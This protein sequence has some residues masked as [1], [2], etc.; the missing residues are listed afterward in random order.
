[1]KLFR[2]SAAL[3]AAALILSHAQP[4][5]AGVLRF[6]DVST[7]MTTAKYW[8]AKQNDAADVLATRSEIK[9]LNKALLADANTHMYD[10]KNLP[11]EVDG[12]VLNETLLKAAKAD[13]AYMGTNKYDAKGNQVTA[14]YY[15]DMVE[16]TQSADT[17]THPVMYGIAVNRT[18]IRVFP[19]D[20]AILDDSGDND[21]DNLYN[22]GLRVNEPF[23][24]ESVSADRKFY[25]GKC[26]CCAGW[27]PAED[28]AIC[29]TR[30]QWLDAWNL[31]S[32][33][34]L[35]VYGSKVYTESSNTAPETANRLLTLGTT[36]ELVEAD[37]NTE[38]ITNRSA[39]NNYVVYLPVR[40]ADG[41]FDKKL[42]LISQNAKVKEGFFKLTQ[43][44]IL[45]VS[46]EM[47]GDTYGWGGMLE[48][49]DCSGYVRDVYRCFG[50]N[51]ARNTT[52]QSSSP[53]KKCTFDENTTGEEKYAIIKNLPAGSTLFFPGHEMTYLGTENGKIYV[54]SSVSSMMNPYKEGQRLR[55]RSVALNTLDIKRA[56]GKTWLESLSTVAIPF[57]GEGNALFEKEFR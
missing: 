22:S 28:V 57:A 55:V 21:F 6:P 15:T 48:S 1:M 9:A 10:L 36:L 23:V 4:L 40:K 8:A 37:E 47:L 56:N 53:V 39:Y 44:N 30:R 7:K 54:I 16:N 25:Y 14:D 11:R 13:A 33:S 46:F 49:D 19:T 3:L 17:S 43:K 12:S 50:L 32:D 31:E 2:V 52:W 27:V 41:S 42:A 24:I 45:K 51:L 18:T 26:D 35:L 29:G 38:L 20:K 5:S 34:L